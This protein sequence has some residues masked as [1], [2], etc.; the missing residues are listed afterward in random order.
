VI[1][2]N[3]SPADVGTAEIINSEVCTALVF[4]LEPAKAFRLAGFLVPREF[5]EN[6]LAIL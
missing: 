4:V 5:E 1:D 2:A 3:H 6:G